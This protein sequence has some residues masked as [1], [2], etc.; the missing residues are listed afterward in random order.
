MNSG[1]RPATSESTV[2]GAQTLL[3]ALDILD[4]FVDAG[5]GTLSLAEIS[6]RLGLTAPTTH[7]LV[8]ALISRGFV[9]GGANRRYGLGPAV[10]RLASVVMHRA[11]D[12]I[13]VAMPSL[14]RLRETTGETVSLHCRVGDERVCVAELISAQPIRMASGVGRVYPL[15][16]GAAGKA[17]LAW[18]PDALESVR[19]RLAV[20]GP[21]TIAE[22]AELDAELRRIRKRGYAVSESE[23]VAG[24]ASLAMPV[25]GSSGS[26]IA[27]INIAGPSMR[28]NR[29]KMAKCRDDLRREVEALMIVTA[30]SGPSLARSGAPPVR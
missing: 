25:F 15:Y 14:E 5:G 8:K 23:V 20:V 9:V 11:D 22:P 7:R 21:A 3:R 6:R 24:A 4:C 17:M 16:A 1:D 28:W 19:G 10:M 2:A 30:S 13:A 18:L 27:A 29:S 26:V 12:L